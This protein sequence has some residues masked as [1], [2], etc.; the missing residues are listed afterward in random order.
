MVT[1]FESGGAA[2]NQLCAVYDA[3]LSVIGLDLD[4]PTNDFTS[5]VA[6]PESECLA[7]INAGAVSVDPQ[8]DLLIL[9]EMGIG[10]STVAA[11]L[12]CALLGGPASDWV[13]A[14]TGADSAGMD[15]KVKAVKNGLVRHQHDLD[16]PLR[17]LMAFGGREQAAIVGAVLAARHYSIP[18]ILDGFI[19]SARGRRCRETLSVGS[20]PLPRRALFD[21][22][23]TRTPLARARKGALASSGDEAWRGNRG[24]DGARRHS[25]GPRLPQW[26]GDIRLGRGRFGRRPPDMI[27]RRLAD[28]R[29]AVM[30]LTRLPVWKGTDD[31]PPDLSRSVWAYPLVGALV[32]GIGAAA[33]TVFRNLVS[34]QLSAVVAFTAMILATGAFHEDGLAGYSRW[35]GRRVGARTKARNHARQSDRHLR[36]DR[37]HSEP[38]GA[39][40]GACGLHLDHSRRCCFGHAELFEPW[41]NSSVAGKL[42]SL[43]G[44]REWVRLVGYPGPQ[45]VLAGILLAVAPICVLAPFGERGGVKC[46]GHRNLH[47][48]GSGSTAD[49]EDIPVISWALAN[50]CVNALAGSFSQQ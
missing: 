22:T 18:V 13:G 45:A 19:C 24:R 12:A 48:V 33:F 37:R 50:R 34:P 5:A 16:D 32:G 38:A 4:Q 26:Y 29:A 46:G 1:N 9:G 2:I 43:R 30:L 20:R 15:R 11:A 28:I 3:K 17:I 27:N 8:A 40:H 7:A 14:G 42:L 44:L 23:G 31:G 6:L 39:R 49:S 41:R 21:G 35:F 47:D 10:N 25:R 36:N